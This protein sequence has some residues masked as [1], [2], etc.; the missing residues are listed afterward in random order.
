MRGSKNP[1]NNFKIKSGL[2]KSILDQSWYDFRRKLDYTSNWLGG[3]VLLVPPKHTLQTCPICGFV[4]QKENRQTPEKFVYMNC[5]HASHA[6]H[7]AVRNIVERG[8]RVFAC[9]REVISLLM[10]EP[11]RY[12]EVISGY[13]N[14]FFSKITFKIRF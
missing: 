14:R 11:V 4:A 1:G 10:Q 8:Q 3:K 6:D 9:G 12:R 2:K 5:S 7:I 13:F